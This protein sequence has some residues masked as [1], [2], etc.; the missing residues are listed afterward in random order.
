M[1]STAGSADNSDRP[2]MVEPD[3]PF[4]APS[5][6]PCKREL[7]VLLDQFFHQRGL[8]GELSQA[9]GEGVLP[10]MRDV[11]ECLQLSCLRAL[12]CGQEGRRVFG[13]F[14][15]AVARAGL[16]ASMFW[17]HAFEIA[18]WYHGRGARCP[19]AATVHD[20]GGAL[21]FAVARFSMR[22]AHG[23]AALNREF[24]PALGRACQRVMRAHITSMAA[25]KAR[26]A[27]Q[28]QLEAEVA[29]LKAYQDT[30][31]TTI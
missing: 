12:C 14:A 8:G 24:S 30:L 6:F 15:R 20:W 19:F 27:A 3:D 17:V 22:L 7:C 31:N 23:R 16:G 28:A 26:S 21:D 10:S 9:R 18:G 1:A 11:Y 13:S 4:P 5:A 29:D 25:A 2:M